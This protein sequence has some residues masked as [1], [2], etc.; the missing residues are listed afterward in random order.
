MPAPIAHMEH[1]GRS[2]IPIEWA[3]KIV[4]DPTAVH[5]IIED[6][7][8]AGG[9]SVWYGASGS[10]KTTLLLDAMLRMPRERPWL[11]KRLE[12]G[13]SVL[14]CAESP[15]S[16]RLRVAAFREHHGGDIGSFAIIPEALN[17]L[18]GSADVDDLIDLLIR[19]SN[20]LPVPLAL[21][22][23]DTVARVMLGGDENTAE[24]MGRLVAAGDRIRRE[25]A[26][27]VAFVHHSGKD[28]SLGARG[29]SSLRAATD[30][31]IEVTFDK[32]TKLH[33][34]EITKQRDLGSQGLKLS[35]RF[36]PVE[37]GTNQWGNPITACVVEQDEPASEHLRA[38]MQNVE[39]ERAEGVVMAGFHRL[40]ELGIAPADVSNAQGYLPRQMVDKGLADG[41][42]KA[43]LTSAMNRLM[44]RGTLIR[45]QVGKYP[46]S[47][48]HREGLVLS[49][50]VTA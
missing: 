7:L 40:R 34:V 45:G 39:H 15:S 16:A 6:V 28:A 23:I 33:T 46:G 30:T 13:A 11:G 48:H 1:F 41:F 49:S 14:V 36:L 38:V 21:I 43:A 37:L 29:H 25:L 44:G 42:D 2:A 20:R 26:V 19:E 10:G 8:V 31:E 9:M 50:E 4:F 22:G 5:E 18:N 27:H 24:D 32:A 35:A 12:R 17:L 47:R 3:P